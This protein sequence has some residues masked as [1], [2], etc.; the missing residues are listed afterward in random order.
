MRHLRSL[1]KLIAT[2]LWVLLTWH[3]PITF[4]KNPSEDSGWIE[5]QEE[6]GGVQNRCNAFL[7]KIFHPIKAHVIGGYTRRDYF[8]LNDELRGGFP[9]ADSLAKAERL[10]KILAILPNYEGPVL[11][12]VWLENYIVSGLREDKNFKDK[13]FVSATL[14]FT[15]RS[16]VDF[17]KGYDP[18]VMTF[19]EFRIISKTGKRIW[20][21]SDA[22]SEN[23]V[24][25]R[26][27][28]SFKIT[29]VED[30][31]PPCENCAAYKIV[32]MTEIPSDP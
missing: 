24:L 28:I 27:N 1:I 14:D 10:E 13:G 29:K 6:I 31:P 17:Q 25:F 23:E 16:P 26:R 7:S 12:R 18:S 20:K 3:T 8:K 30:A 32:T 21:W 19:V 4:A 22:Y 5:N 9:D 2:F 15:M 11:R